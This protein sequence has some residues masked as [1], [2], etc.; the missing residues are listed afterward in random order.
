MPAL[1]IQ[2]T[3][4]NGFLG[5]DFFRMTLWLLLIVLAV[6]IPSM[7]APNSRRLP[8]HGATHP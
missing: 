1:L 5:R 2:S 3:V 6:T 4:E 8:G 7:V